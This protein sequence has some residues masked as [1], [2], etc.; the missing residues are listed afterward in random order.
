M[1]NSSFISTQALASEGPERRLA[2]GVFGG[3]G[4][5]VPLLALVTGIL[6]LA[7]TFA[8]SLLAPMAWMPLPRWLWLGFPLLSL[9]GLS[10]GAWRLYTRLLKPLTRLEEAVTRVCQGEP[11]AGGALRELGHQAGILANLT[12][13]IDS[14][15]EELTDLYEDMDNR[16]A[17]QTTRLAQKTAS[18]KILYDVA[19]GI[20]EAESLDSLLLRFLRVLKEMVN[21]RAATARLVKPDGSRRLV[22]SIGL[23]ETRVGDPAA[24][25]LDLCLCGNVLASGDILCDNDQR[26]CSRVYGRRMFRGDEIEV[27]TIPLEHRDELLGYYTIFVDKPGIGGREDILELLFSIGHHLGIAVAKHHSDADA[28]RLSIMEERNSLANELHDSLAQTLASLR[29]Q[30]NLFEESLVQTPIPDKARVDLDRLR[31]GLDEA[32]RELRSLLANFRAPMDRRGLVPALERITAAFRQATGLKVLFQN[33][34]RAFE[35][36]AA[37]ELQVTRITQEALANIRKHARAHTVRVLLTAKIEG[38]QVLLIEDDGVGFQLPEPEGQTGEHIGLSIMRER[39]RRMGAELR[40]ESE[41][42]EGTRVELHFS[43]PDR[44]QL[45]PVGVT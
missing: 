32:H 19:A 45:R 22:G 6:G 14:L 35:L 30:V 23:D 13:A 16:V 11:G 41:P 36:P 40:I 20:N 5:T 33:N 29:L 38:D 31:G 37:A 25:P 42:E 9:G 27:V 1:H 4:L 44:R 7:L 28:L 24:M 39:A 21:G 34:L 18:I 2:A 8:G 26:Y 43:L 17:R 15:N 10:L 3:V 12:Q